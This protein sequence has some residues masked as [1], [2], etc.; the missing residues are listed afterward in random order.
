MSQSLDELK[1]IF[2][3][4]EN[5]YHIPSGILKEIYTKESEVVHY[6]IREQ[7][8]PQLKRIIEE[9]ALLTNGWDTSEVQGDKD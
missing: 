1:K 7:I 6:A 3:E 8:F 2:E 4:I 5:K 9:S